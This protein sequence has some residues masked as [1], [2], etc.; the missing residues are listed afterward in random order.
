MHRVNKL[1]KLRRRQSIFL[2]EIE[3]SS[4]RSWEIASLDTCIAEQPTLRSLLMSLKTKDGISNLF[5]SVDTAFKKN[6]LV[7]FTF[8]PRYE[9]EARSFVS[10]LVPHMLNLHSTLFMSEYFTQEACDRAQESEWDSISDK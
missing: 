1:K 3:I 2:N 6:D 4:T 7:I 8:L 10:T 5:L 9:D